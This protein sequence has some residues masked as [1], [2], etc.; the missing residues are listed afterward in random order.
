MLKLV[1]VEVNKRKVGTLRY[2][3]DGNRLT[4]DAEMPV[5]V[6]DV[7]CSYGEHGKRV[8]FEDVAD[9]YE[10]GQEYMLTNFVGEAPAA[11]ATPAPVTE[12]PAPAPPPE[13]SP[14]TPADIADANAANP[15]IGA[16]TP[17]TEGTADGEIAPEAPAPDAV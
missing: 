17:S 5:Y 1:V 16:P 6:H 13:S 14:V 8:T 12:F 3:D 4:P 15:N 7:T 2:D 11:P 10:L 9:A